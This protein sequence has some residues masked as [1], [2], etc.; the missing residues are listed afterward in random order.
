MEKLDG[1][2]RAYCILPKQ[3]LKA[4][5]SEVARVITQFDEFK[6]SSHSKNAG[7]LQYIIDHCE[8]E[9]IAYNLTAVP[10]KGY[11]LQRLRYD[12]ISPNGDPE[13]TK[14]VQW[15]LSKSL[16]AA[17]W[18]GPHRWNNILLRYVGKMM[19]DYAKKYYNDNCEQGL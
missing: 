13:T 10:G 2:K 8:K 9:K 6:S 19:R 14:A 16:P 1:R 12:Y 5:N 18:G 3:P 11:Y 15:L 17:K 7:L 4:K